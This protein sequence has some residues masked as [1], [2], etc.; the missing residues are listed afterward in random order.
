MP[1]KSWNADLLCFFR[2]GSHF[3][4][5]LILTFFLQQ[6]TQ[7]KH[8]KGEKKLAHD[9]NFQSVITES[10][11]SRPRMRQIS[12]LGIGE[13]GCSPWGGLKQREAEG[14]SEFPVL[15]KKAYLHC[16]TSSCWHS[17][18]LPPSNLYYE[19]LNELNHWWNHF[20][21]NHISVIGCS[22]GRSGFLTAETFYRAFQRKTLT[23]SQS[24]K[25]EI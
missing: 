13:E 14:K 5:H 23:E 19:S 18:P 3:S 12:I 4:S 21:I 25:R 11:V 22:R 2:Y 24:S 6:N 15:P 10:I 8:L 16:S 17:Y 1:P 7:E 20:M 9:F